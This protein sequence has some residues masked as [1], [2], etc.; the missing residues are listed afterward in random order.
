M[1]RIHYRFGYVLVLIVI[2]AFFVMA[3]PRGDTARFVSVSLQAA[4]L[5]AAVIAS[6]MP[7]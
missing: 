4:V 7:R 2:A 3:A 6:K 1:H 5:V